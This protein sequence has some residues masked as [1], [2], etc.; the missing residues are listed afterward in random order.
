MERDKEGSKGMERRRGKE[1]CR[2]EEKKECSLFLFVSL[3]ASVSV[4][5]SLSLSLCLSLSVSLSFFLLRGEGWRGE[6][7]RAGNEGEEGM[8]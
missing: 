2:R 8:E 6:E 4:S 5:L 7:K 3:S 1:Q